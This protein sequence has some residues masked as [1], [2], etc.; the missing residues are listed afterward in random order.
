M[1]GWKRLLVG[2]N[3]EV[4]VEPIGQG[5]VIPSRRLAVISTRRS[6]KKKRNFPTESMMIPKKI[7][8]IHTFSDVFVDTNGWASFLQVKKV[9][10]LKQQ[11]FSLKFSKREK[12]VSNPQVCH[13]T[14]KP[15]V[16]AA[17]WAQN[18]CDVPARKWS[19]QWWS[20]HWLKSSTCRDFRGWIG[21]INH[22]IT[23]K[24]LTSVVCNSGKL[25]YILI[26]TSNNRTSKRRHPKLSLHGSFLNIHTSVPYGLLSLFIATFR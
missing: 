11:V 12:S 23:T 6:V 5:L 25:T 20:D 15:T 7:S 3:D 19:D 13:P 10:I 1:S 24:H 4:Y 22:F 21:V 18:Y 16:L 8:T 2:I 14:R 26:L 9:A 17:A